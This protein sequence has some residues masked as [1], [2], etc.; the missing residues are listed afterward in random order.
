LVV[1]INKEDEAKKAKD[2]NR[3]EAEASFL[4]FHKVR[5]TFKSDGRIINDTPTDTEPVY[6]PQRFECDKCAKFFISEDELKNHTN[7]AK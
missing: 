7:M 4:E 3:K 6:R 1:K 2:E 5:R